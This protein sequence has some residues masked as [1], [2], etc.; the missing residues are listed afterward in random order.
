MFKKAITLAAITLLAGTAY[1]QDA[2]PAN[3][4]EQPAKKAEPVQTLKAGD[5]APAINVE[6]WVKGEPITGFEAGR[7][8]VVEFWA[9]WCGPCIAQMPHLS[10]LATQ[11]KD[12]GVAVVGVNIWERKYDENTL[13]SV[14]KFVENKG[15]DMGYTVAF[16]GA[17]KAM[18]LAYMKAANRRGI[19]STFVVDGKG[20]VAWIGHPM[21]LDEVVAQVVE[22]T[23]DY[24]ASAAAI[25]EA[26][27]QL[28][29]AF[30]NAAKDPRAAMT[31]FASVEA[32]F[33]AVAN[34]YEDLK[35]NLLLSSG[36]FDRAYGLGHE[37]VQ[38][39][40][41]KKDANKLNGIAWAIVNPE[42]EIARRDLVLAFKAAESA[43]TF[44][45][46]TN[47]G[48]MDTL[49]RVYFLQGN[50]DQAIE[51]QAKAVELVPERAKEQYT[52]ALD[53]Y[54]AAKK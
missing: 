23:W 9:T 22:G 39:A 8:Y 16:D 33:P 1:A 2:A 54:K 49:A 48:I 20:N 5:K 47:P 53:E 43:N 13:D 26:T 46:G 4:A 3:K 52:K 50:I 24:V 7:V 29:T 27:E 17:A 32:K 42:T 6:T 51:L 15:D 36:D 11:Y 34:Q 21:W 19:P 38:G 18:D 31:A 41:A 10:H 28:D 40:L 12:K 45:G 44:S 35:F 14:K 37:L 30:A 25:D